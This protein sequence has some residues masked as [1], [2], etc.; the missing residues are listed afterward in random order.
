MS[1]IFI[2][3]ARKDI[4]KAQQLAE[5][6]EAQGWSVFWDRTIPAGQSWRS[7]I[8]KALEE[9][10]CV[11]VAW[12]IAS[13]ESDWVLEEAD[14]AKRRRVLIP[15]LTESVTPPLGFG[16]IHAADLVGWDGNATTNTFIELLKPIATLL[17]TPPIVTQEEERRK[18]E[19]EAE[20]KA[21][22][23]ERRKLELK[24]KRKADQERQAKAAAEVKR[25]TEETERTH[26]AEANRRPEEVERQNAAQLETEP[27]TPNAA[28]ASETVSP[29]RSAGGPARLFVATLGSG[30][31]GG[32]VAT[33]LIQPLVTTTDTSVPKLEGL[34]MVTYTVLIAAAVALSTWPLIRLRK[35]PLTWLYGALA[36]LAAIS[37]PIGLTLA[38]VGSVGGVGWIRVYGG[39]VTAVASVLVAAFFTYR[40]TRLQP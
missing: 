23:E 12:S 35:L 33:F 20:R 14:H 18:A 38:G 1:D 34:F 8:G 2:S 22:E 21:E 26:A 31:M 4:E 10:R 5:A 3:Y 30:S 7:Y 28:S 9:A 16:A 24:A 39:Y 37:F 15:V 36:R 17:G 13:T 6:L 32:L 19:L 25:E 11:I 40:A 29:T 27:T